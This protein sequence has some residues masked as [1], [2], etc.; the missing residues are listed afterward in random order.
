[1]KAKW[2]QIAC[3]KPGVSKCPLIRL[4]QYLLSCLLCNRVRC[5]WEHIFSCRPVLHKNQTASLLWDG[6]K[7]KSD[8]WWYIFSMMQGCT[9][10]LRLNKWQYH[11]LGRINMITCFTK[12]N[13]VHSRSLSASS[14]WWTQAEMRSQGRAAISLYLASGCAFLSQ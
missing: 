12:F 10:H 8:A 14:W 5:V 1:M 2:I 9:R 3:R 7:N 4:M 6:R 11:N 13:Q